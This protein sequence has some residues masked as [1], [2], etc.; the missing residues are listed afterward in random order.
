MSH[1]NTQKPTNIDKLAV[2]KDKYSGLNN[3]GIVNKYSLK[4]NT[5]KDYFAINGKW[6]REY[7]NYS[8]EMNKACI[9]TAKVQLTKSV[10]KAVSTLTSLLNS[11]NPNVA[12]KA[13]TEVINRCLG[14]TNEPETPNISYEYAEMI[15]D[16]RADIMKGRERR[17]KEE[18]H[19]GE[20]E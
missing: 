20:K 13:S 12:L 19:A 5:V 16:I 11:D 18:E 1:N 4:I 2:F 14:N 3:K 10:E 17:K 9:D 15:D 6:H 7:M 8:N